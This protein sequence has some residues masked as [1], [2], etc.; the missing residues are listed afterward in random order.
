[1][2][3]EAS[4][5]RAEL[6]KQGYAH[7]GYIKSN[8]RLIESW[9]QYRFASI[10]SRRFVIDGQYFMELKWARAYAEGMAEKSEA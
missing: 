5:I 2:S 7:R 4:D 8:G 1:V 6:R 9:V 3:E 10:V